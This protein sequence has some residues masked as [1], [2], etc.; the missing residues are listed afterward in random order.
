[1][2]SPA[3]KM[4]SK[5]RAPLAGWRAIRFA[6]NARPQNQSGHLIGKLPQGIPQLMRPLID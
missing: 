1:M 2:A 5:R 3:M 4:D 6:A